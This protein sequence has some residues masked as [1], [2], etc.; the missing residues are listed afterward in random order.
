MR[1]PDFQ[2]TK[3]NV[4]PTI[5]ASLTGADGKPLVLPSGSTVSFRMWVEGNYASPKVNAPAVFVSQNQGGADA[6][7]SVAE[8][9]WTSGDTDTAEVYKARFICLPLG[10]STPLD[11]P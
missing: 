3:G 6:T 2:L 7:L 9:Q 10:S 11:V 5:R 4:A 8:Y 1:T